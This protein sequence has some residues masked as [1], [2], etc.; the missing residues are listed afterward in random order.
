MDDAPGHDER[1]ERAVW[2]ASPAGRS[3]ISAAVDAR[4][5]ARGDAL[6]AATLLRSTV[7]VSPDHLA[8]ALEQAELAEVAA[9]RHGIDGPDLLFT[10][11]GLEAATRPMVADRRAQA[12]TRAGAR[13]ILDLTGGLGFDTAAFLRAGLQVTSVERDPV[14]AIFLRH[15]C[16]DATV[17]AA[18]ATDPEVLASLL[19]GLEPTDIVFVDP[20]R[21]DPSAA[22]DS[23]TG[24]AR[25]ERDPER[26]SPPWSWV[27]AIAHPRVAAK[28]APSFTPPSGWY[29]EWVSVDR[30]VVECTVRSWPA[31]VAD[32]RAVVLGAD[33]T[34]VEIRADHDDPP[35]AEAIGSWLH[36]L[37]PAVVQA[38]AAGAL[39]RSESLTW[40]GPGTTWLTG[41]HASVHPALRSHEVLADLPANDRQ[42]RRLLADRGIANASVKTK[43][44][45]VAPRD[46][47]RALRLQEGPSPVIVI[48]SV[49]GRQRR[50]LA[51]PAQP[52]R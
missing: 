14:I 25:P 17:V 32:R 11:D 50:V 37:D 15:N 13:R 41:D 44:V 45:S 6:R 26:W 3:A 43:D 34:A 33:G 18:D 21:R 38:G 39:A 8:A 20:A 23:R 48:T 49:G 12:F 19:R 30:T 29:A 46:A 24:R 31:G 52:R 47:L 4:G 36:E 16:P 7:E 5:Q 22:R 28:V 27:H 10:R 1:R 2:L 9:L 51:G 42:A 40:L 35:M